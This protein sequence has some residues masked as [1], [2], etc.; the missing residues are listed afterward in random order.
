MT[1]E[2][3]IK[4]NK[5]RPKLPLRAYWDLLARHPGSGQGGPDPA[6][7][8]V[9]PQRARFIALIV[10]MLV[11]IGLQLL[12]PLIMRNFIDQALA[13]VALQRLMLSA[14]AFLGIA[15]LQQAVSVSVVYN[16]ESLAWT[17]TNALRGE[18]ARHCLNLDMSFHNK[19]TPGELIERIDGDVAEMSAF[20]SQF[21]ITLLG[22][23]VLLV[24][25]L[26]VLTWQDW[27]VGLVFTLYAGAALAFLNRV[28]DYAVDDQKARRE[29]EAQYFGFVEEQ[30]A[31]TEDLRSSGADGFVMRE[32]HR[33]QAAFYTADRRGS[34]K[35]WLV[36]NAMVIVLMLGALLAILS[37]YF[38][39]VT[40]AVSIGTVFLIVR[41]FSL[42]E[43]PVW[44]LTHEMR[45]FQTIG[46][47]VERLTEL[48]AIQPTVREGAGELLPSGALPLVFEDVSFFYD[49]G[50]PVLNGLS[51]QLQPGRVLGLLGRTGSGK[52]TLARLVFRLYDPT[53]GRIKLDG[54][55]LRDLRL[56]ALRGRVALVTQDVQIFRASVRDN[57]TFFDPSLPDERIHA[58]LAELG[59]QDWLSSLPAGLD[60]GLESGGRSL[61]AGEAQLLALARVFLRDPGL[62]ILDEASSRLDP[63]TEQRLE[64]AIDRLLLGRTAVIIAHRLGTVHRADEILILEDGAAGEMGPRLQ[65]AA[66]PNS[67]FSH[68]LQTGLEEV[69]V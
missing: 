62:V 53:A 49:P 44:V 27:R 68:L 30:L 51:F 18:L 2:S 55:D 65:L 5:P 43:G 26:A 16:G 1:A 4:K 8:G 12:N 56:Q 45:T 59:L 15:I 13:G 60:S 57:L 20:F 58:V 24:G 14:L 48:R 46:A 17:A 52:S 67:R 6:Q 61:S 34:F 39:Y 36:T 38:L 11:N 7:G 47:C 10:L 29:V 19:R 50:E 35:N 54:S 64:R 21:L 23:A 32:L 33:L 66:D 40:A 37:G 9:R 3:I 41:Y 31:G 28:R 63:A 69:L 25:I 22:N 42:L